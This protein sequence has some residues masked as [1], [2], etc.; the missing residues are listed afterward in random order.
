M[1]RRKSVAS[2]GSGWRIS[3]GT[4]PTLA[5]PASDLAV[6]GLGCGVAGRSQAA[7][8]GR[9]ETEAERLDRNYGE[10]LQELRVAQ[11][12]VQILF[13]SLLTV[14]FSERFTTISTSSAGRTW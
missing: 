12:G 9:N 13:A 10:L 6:P 5:G 14:V 2:S 7:A 4:R 1:V 3:T 8:A 11:V